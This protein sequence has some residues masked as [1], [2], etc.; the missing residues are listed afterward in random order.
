M[1][2]VRGEFYSEALGMNTQISA[3]LPDEAIVN[4][5]VKGKKYPTLYMLHGAMWTG[6][7]TLV[8]TNIEADISAMFPELVVI[9]PSANF[10]F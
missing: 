9:M 7:H 10:S 5:N 4:G 2:I 3:I 6:L 1:T 8:G